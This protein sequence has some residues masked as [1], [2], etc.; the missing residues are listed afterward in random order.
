MAHINKFGTIVTPNI[1]TAKKIILVY[2]SKPKHVMRLMNDEKLHDIVVA[3]LDDAFVYA[4]AELG[5]DPTKWAWGTIHHTNFT[6]PL[7][8]IATGE[9]ADIMRYPEFPRGG[10]GNTTNNT[11]YHNMKLEV[12]RGSSY[13]QVIDVGDWDASRMTNTPG[14]SGDPRSP[15]YDNLLK[16]WAEEESFPLIYTRAKVEEHR[17]LTITLNPRD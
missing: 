14:Q 7:Q 11:G 17:V 8:H 15:F 1:I 10:N 12:D 13:R 5:D 6:H 9:L 16:G 4:T 2:P 3:T